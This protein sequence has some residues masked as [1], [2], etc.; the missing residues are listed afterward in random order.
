MPHD[1]EVLSFTIEKMNCAS[2]V[3]KIENRLSLVEGV[4]GS[5]VNFATGHANIEVVKGKVSEQYL[6]QAIS[7][8]GYPAKPL[9][10]EE[11]IETS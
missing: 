7:D 5:S 2:C 9:K 8:L 1:T 10:E 4:V 11:E 6:A 3:S